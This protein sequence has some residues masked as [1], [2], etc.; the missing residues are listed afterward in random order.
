MKGRLIAYWVT[1][2]LVAFG[3]LT[4][5]AADV[6]RPPDAVAGMAHLG[7]PAYFM[8]ILGV[9]KLLGGIALLAPRFP[10][11][12]EWAYAGAIFD[13]TGASAS[14]AASGDAAWHIIVPLLLAAIAMVSWALR[15]ESRVLGTILPARKA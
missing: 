14:H 5:G 12:K 8:V 9:W 6:M 11:L 7:Y 3:L 2:G 15:P 1:T 13:V 4:G 10:R